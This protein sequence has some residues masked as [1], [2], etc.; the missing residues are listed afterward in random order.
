MVSPT[1]FAMLLLMTLL[2]ATAAQNPGAFVSEIWNACNVTPR[3]ELPQAGWPLGL[4]TSVPT[5][6][7]IYTDGK[8]II[9]KA[10][11]DTYPDYGDLKD[12]KIDGENISFTVI[13]HAKP[14][15]TIYYTG[16]LHG[17]EMDLT[18]RWSFAGQTMQLKMKAKRFQHD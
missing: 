15:E 14:D 12:G 11:V 17:D 16:Q 6:F 3:D 8:T 13:A 7:L 4:H 18:M 5:T 9:G 1:A 10:I 2:Q